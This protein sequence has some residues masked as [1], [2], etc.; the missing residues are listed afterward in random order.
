MIHGHWIG[1]GN[2]LRT[3][4]ALK[5][6]P[7]EAEVL[8]CGLGW[9]ELYINGERVEDEY[10]VPAQTDYEKR[11]FYRRYEVASRL[12]CGRNAIG[13]RLGKG[14][15][16]QDKVL[17]RYGWAPAPYGGVRAVLELRAWS[18]E[19][20]LFAWT[21]H[22]C[23]LAA[24]GPVTED[25]VYWGEHFDARLLQADWACPGTDVTG[26][27]R[28][29]WMSSPT[30][31]LQEQTLEPERITRRLAP[32]AVT[33]L[34]EGG[35]LYDF[36]ENIAGVAELTVEAPAGSEV[37]LE[38]AEELDE[39][40]CFDPAST[41]VFAT[42]G[43]ATDRYICAGQGVERWHPS[44]T[45]H[46]FRYCRVTGTPAQSLTACEIHT[47]VAHTGCFR[48]SDALVEEIYA[49]C[50]RTLLG[51]LHSL[52][53]DCP[54]REKCGWLGDAQVEAEFAIY[55]FDCRKLFSKYVDDIATSAQIGIPTMVAPGSRKCGPA[56]PG[57]GTA[58][59]QLPWY[60]YL[61]YGD[62][63][64]MR[65]H[66]RLMK[67]WLAHLTA[68]AQDHIVGYGLGDWCPPGSV[69]PTATPVA[70]T[71]TA[72]YFL[73]TELLSRMAHLLGEFAD[74]RKFAALAREIRAAFHR[75]F[76]DPAQNSYGSQTGNALALAYDLVPEESAVGTAAALERDVREHGFHFTTGISGLRHLFEQLSRYGYA[77]SAWKCLTVSGYPGF[78][79]LL[80]RGA[81]TCW[82]TWE[83][84]PADEPTPRSRNHPMQTGWAAWLASGVAGFA[85]DWERPGWEHVVFS[86][87]FIPQL[88]WAEAELQTVR[89]R[90]FSRWRR[91]GDGRIDWEIGMPQGAGFTVRLP[92]KWQVAELLGDRHFRLTQA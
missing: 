79:D 6:E 84:N 70:L 43:I 58:I 14:F 41:G 33:A 13:I 90:I 48:S 3:E 35:W 39:N 88:E 24:D 21:T 36:G 17:D 65:K 31:S 54:A 86:P 32:A 69:N 20:E 67:S 15:F 16:G 78:A 25:N 56:T 73:D 2:L 50:R 29:E 63:Q 66:Y 23:W 53:T 64:P 74:A 92:E 22:E 52:P 34:P 18:P 49:M 10:F 26:W 30:A 68:Q 42:G 40:G 77:E 38:F 57:W 89:G 45:Y 47:D 55:N 8:I 9:F 87:C 82:E 12:R 28:A 61:Y 72:Y 71:S 44:F 7:R 62:I 85:P 81:T 19:R 76:F 4:F 60:L 83:K 46:G 51:N 59:V 27:R 37:V 1:G 5:W 11:A 75:E 80:A 91:G